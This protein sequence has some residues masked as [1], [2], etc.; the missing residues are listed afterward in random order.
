MEPWPTGGEVALQELVRSQRAMRP[1]IR[2]QT[3][4][5]RAVT[6][7]TKAHSRAIFALIDRLESGGGPA[8]AT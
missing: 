1:E 2:A 7:T 3:E 4:E 8:P 6:E 5:I